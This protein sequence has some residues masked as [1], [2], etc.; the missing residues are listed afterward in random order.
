MDLS[1]TSEQKM[2]L[3]TASRLA[4]EVLAPRAA[5][6]DASCGFPREG[7]QRL[8]EAGLMGILIPPALGG[9]G[10]DTLS[11]VLATEELAKACGSTALSY[12]TQ[13]A[14]EFTILVGGTAEQKARYLPAMCSGEKL[15]LLAATEPNSGSNSMVM[16]AFAERQNDHYVL[17]G[18]KNFITNGGEAA[19][20]LVVVRTNKAPG[21]QSLSLFIVDRDTPGFTIGKRDVRMGF[22]GVSSSELIFQNCKVPADNLIGQEGAGAMTV[23]AAGGLSTLGAAA[24]SIGLAQAALSASV[25]WAKERVI[26][27]QPIGAYQGIQFLITEMSASVAAARALLY[28]AVYTR[29][30]SPPGLSVASF[31]AKLFASEMAVDVTNKALQIHGGHGYSRELPLER[32]FRDARGVTL[33]FSP[34]EPLKELLGKVTLGLFP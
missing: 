1:L 30:T 7:L 13:I 12:V 10:G 21:P 24:I 15:G 31:Q 17:N 20:N 28:S 14:S 22:N 2:I 11:F 25:N 32:Y 3:Q 5:E 16:E 23:M 19:V 4:T 26:A 9:G 6:L 34:T 27:G 29:D 18:T 8:A 33:H